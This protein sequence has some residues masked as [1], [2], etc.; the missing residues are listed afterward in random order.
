MFLCATSLW[1][2]TAN[3]TIDVTR[4]GPK[5]NPRMYGVFL[6][7]I[8]HGVDGGLY[9][10]LIRNRG[11]EDSRP[12]EGYI[13]RHGR[14]VDGHG[15]D[16]GFSRYGYTTDGIPFWSLVREGDAKGAINLEKTGGITQQSAYCLRLDIETLSGGRL[17]VANTGF[18]GIGVKQG[19]A[20]RFSLYARAG[21]GFGGPLFIRMEDLS[22]TACSNQVKI[23]GLSAAWTQFKGTLTASK[24]ESKARLVITAG[25]TGRVWLD[26]VSLFPRRTWRNRAN[27]LRPDIAQ[28]IADL[29]PGFVRFPGGCVVEGGTVETAYNWKLTVGPLTERSERWGPWN[30][31]RTQG[32][33]LYE[34]LQFC[35]DLSAEPLWVGF[36]GQTCIFREREN[37]PMRDM[38]W[39]RDNFLDLVDYANGTAESTWGAVRAN[40]GHPSS[41]DLKYVEI[42]NENQ[43]PEYGERYRYVYNALKSRYPGLTY[44]ADLSWTSRESLG[45]AVFDIED[46]HYYNSP[47]WFISRFH[48]Y[49]SRD[50]NLPPLYLGEVAVTSPDGGPLRGNL[51]AALAEGVFLMGCERNADAVRMV[52]YAPLLGHVEGRTELTNAPPPWHALIYFD[53]TRVFGTASYYLW[54]LFA[55]NRPTQTVATT[56]SLPDVTPAP[57]QGRIG[58]GT[59]DATAEFRDIRVEKAGRLVYASDFAGGSSGWTPEGGQWVV[60]D[61]AYRQNRRG[62]GLSYVGD[63]TWDNYTLT[64][65]ARKLS[66]GEGFLIVFGRK[67]TDRYWWNLGG[68]GNSRHAIEANQNP[69]GTSVSG[70]IETNRWYDIKVEINDR[71]IRCYLDGVLVHDTVVPSDE[72]FFAEAGV[73]EI[74]GD[75]VLKAINTAGEPV[76][77]RLSFSGIPSLAPRAEV[78]VL[79]SALP[80]DNNSL[81]EPFKVSPHVTIVDVA[82]AETRMEFKPYSL[83][84]VRFRTQSGSAAPPEPPAIM[85]IDRPEKGFFAK[86]LDLQGIPIKASAEVVDEALLAAY[87]RLGRMMAKLPDVPAN[88]A[89]AGVELHIIGRSQVTTDLPEWRKDKGKPLPEYNGLTRDQRT[90]GMGGR[91]TSCGEENLLKLENDRYRG[92]DICVHEFAHSILEWGTPKEIRRRFEEQRKR[93]LAAGLWVN[94][95]A[96]SNVD[97]YFAELAMWYFGTH[98]D[99]NMRGKKPADGR[100]GLKDYDPDAF[101]LVDDFW[102]GRIPVPKMDR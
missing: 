6:E 4:P 78:S 51:R 5:I 63:E 85:R 37:V 31:R 94:S 32:M 53:G 60:E 8:N 93:S 69:V 36:D 30:Y 44:L 92:R 28:M 79:T 27:G 56:V 9:G 18:F 7:E 52:S 88:L 46:R 47:R 40:A 23:E 43:G 80:S 39:V 26:F 62:R 48:Q 50:R 91:L 3:I 72:T 25:G 86:R 49:D 14:W 102:S 101:A 99:L 66:G 89:T 90:R 59:W 10:E 71:R 42:G 35:E 17:G 97:E 87:D 65:K 100:Q 98:G 77:A 82:G 64:L 33:G 96:G 57:I 20:Y 70:K 75:V 12:P 21:S 2:G 67:G 1:A 81:E 19:N 61:G 83:T 84:L 41:F 58:I 15:F 74:T 34:Y 68:W 24:T 13:L 95:Y 45:N 54:R 55:A 73:E 76:S 16:S 22:G 38:A 29:Q 11:F